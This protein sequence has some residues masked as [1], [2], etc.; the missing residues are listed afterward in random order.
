MR[1]E[2]SLCEYYFSYSSDL[3]YFKDINLIK[4]KKRKVDDTCRNR[5][6]EERKGAICIRLHRSV[7]FFLL[8]F[9]NCTS[10]LLCSHLHFDIERR[11]ASALRYGQSVITDARHIFASTHRQ[12]YSHT[13]PQIRLFPFSDCSDLGTLLISELC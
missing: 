1:R 13:L 8:L 4:K 2:F 5:K 12:T 3:F 9:F 7:S 11:L 10:P 6:K